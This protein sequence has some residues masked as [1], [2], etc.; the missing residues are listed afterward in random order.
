M[1]VVT[2]NIRY[3]NPEDGKQNIKYRLPYIVDKINS[4]QPDI[5]GFQEVLPHIALQL[6]EKLN[7]YYIVGHG[8]NTDY[9]GEQTAIAFRKDVFDLLRMDSFW[10]SQT[11]SIPGSRYKDQSDCPRTCTCVTLY[12]HTED[13]LYRIYNT[14]LDHKGS[15]ARIKGLAQILRRIQSDLKEQEI[16]F[17]LMGD[18][19]TIPDSPELATLHNSDLCIDQTKTINGSFHDFGKVTTSEKIDYIFTSKNISC[20]GVGTWSDC[21]NGIYLSDHYPVYVDVE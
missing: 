4:E 19:N 1:K 18:F 2:F 6:K 21:I 10:L 14:H 11:P 7:N 9:T 8:R 3:D 20:Q 13:K 15:S 16:P 5:I 17:L 12:H